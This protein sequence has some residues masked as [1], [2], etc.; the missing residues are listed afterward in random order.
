VLSDGEPDLLAAVLTTL[1]ITSK[2]IGE[3]ERAQHLY[4]Q[5]PADS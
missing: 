4:A 1:A 2:E 5:G 3:F